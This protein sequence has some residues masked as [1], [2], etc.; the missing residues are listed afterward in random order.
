MAARQPGGLKRLVWALP[1]VTA[2][3]GALLAATLVWIRLIGARTGVELVTSVRP[4]L[5]L[6]LLACLLMWALVAPEWSATSRFF[7]GRFMVFLGT[8]S[9]GVYV[10]H[11]FISYYLTVNHTELEL[12]RWLGSHGAAVALQATLGAS[13]SL[14]VAYVSYELFEKQFLQLKPLFGGTMGPAPELDP[15]RGTTGR[16]I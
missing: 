4:M 15:I 10:Y 14:G 3:V 11:H 9:Y 1:G 5:I 16:W 8:Y 7:R 12:T 2:A 6:M 13:A